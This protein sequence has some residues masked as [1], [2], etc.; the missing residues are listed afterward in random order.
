MYIVASVTSMLT[1]W[2]SLDLTTLFSSPELE[3]G[4]VNIKGHGV[5]IYV[6]VPFPFSH[7]WAVGKLS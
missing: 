7:Q 3:V 6:T 5:A 1:Q 2:F 4:R